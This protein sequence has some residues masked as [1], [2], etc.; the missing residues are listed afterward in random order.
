[1]ARLR[2]IAGSAVGTPQAPANERARPEGRRP[3]WTPPWPSLRVLEGLKQRSG[4][5]HALALVIIA[6]GV[7]FRLIQYFSDRSLWLDESVL[8][9][10]I[11]DRSVGGLSH[12]LDFYQ[13]APLGFLVAVKALVL[14]F[15][16]SEAVL[17]LI[18]LVCGI[19]ALPLMYVVARKV[20]SDVGALI[21]LLLFA[22]AGS[23]VYYSSELKQ[24]SCDV[25]AGLL[26]SAVAITRGRP[27]WRRYGAASVVGAISIWFSHTT[28]FF[29]AAIVIAYGGYFLRER[30]WSDLRRMILPSAL[31]ITSF[32]FFYVISFRDV[33]SL[34]S[35]G[36]ALSNTSRFVDLRADV[37]QA[38]G[39]PLG[40]GGLPE[41]VR[42]VALGSAIVGVLLML[43][44]RPLAAQI[45]GLPI[46][47]MGAAAAIDR[48]PTF[49]RTILF[50]IPAVILFMAHGLVSIWRLDRRWPVLAVVGAALAVL[51]AY[52]PVANAARN[53]AHPRKKEEIKPLLRELV[54]RWRPGDSL[55]VHYGAQY[56]FRYYAECGC[57][58][59]PASA[60]PLSLATR[61]TAG[62]HLFSP[63][64]RSRPPHFVI[65][66]SEGDANARRRDL[67]RMAGLPRVWILFSHA[68]SR[69]GLR[70]ENV[71]LPRYLDTFGTSLAKFSSVGA[72]LF[73]YDLA[74]KRGAR[75]G[76]R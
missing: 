38:I 18:P 19:A 46:V 52:H 51:V 26:I 73:L 17:R 47:L 10:N 24:Y 74:S 61:R 25:A 56:A 4:L 31:W 12:T 6:G 35:G 32:A 60:P 70:F 39:L 64:L 20:T 8:A 75:A 13:G 16:K 40:S 62:P 34:E 9:L 27:T 66:I 50:I 67:R 22:C 71:E 1:M 69:S 33:K 63:A 28:A 57:L 5:V 21:A 44:R 59:V 42:P 23:L 68:N 43:R 72:T 3:V 11:L 55:Y 29:V 14:A 45:L 65:G 37:A 30:S 53:V 49:E 2:V 41:L 7:A 54:R 48:Y 76:N 36:G 58:G 15:G